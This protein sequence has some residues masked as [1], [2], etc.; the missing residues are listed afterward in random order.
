M[1]GETKIFKSTSG[2][3]DVDNPTVFHPTRDICRLARKADRKVLPTAIGTITMPVYA[4][5]PAVTVKTRPATPSL[6]SL[7]NR[8]MDRL[9]LQQGVGEFDAL[10]VITTFGHNAAAS[11]GHMRAAG[12][13][14]N[15]ALDVISLGVP[16]LSLAY[17]LAR[18]AGLDHADALKEAWDADSDG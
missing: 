15:E 4:S 8:L 16:D 17:G 5:P 18:F 3:Y 10:A 9:T 13:T 12:A 11:Y 1:P 6:T 7:Q 2:W 14:H